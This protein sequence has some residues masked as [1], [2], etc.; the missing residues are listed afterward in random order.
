MKGKILFCSRIVAAIVIVMLLLQTF[1]FNFG[2]KIDA[3]SEEQSSAFTFTILDKKNS[4][5]IKDA[6]ISVNVTVVNSVYNT[7]E[8]YFTLD[9]ITDD[10]G[11]CSFIEI[12]ERADDDIELK[13]EY[14]VTKIGYYDQNGEIEISNSNIGF[15]GNVD[16]E[17]KPIPTVTIRGRVRDNENNGIPR[18]KVSLTGYTD[19]SVETKENGK[20]EIPNVYKTGMYL[21]KVEHADYFTYVKEFNIE[22]IDLRDFEQIELESKW[23][24]DELKFKIPFPEPIT[25]GDSFENPASGGSGTGKITYSVNYPNIATVDENGKLDILEAG[26]ITV[27]ATKE[28]DENYKSISATYNLIINKADQTD[29]AFT[30]DEI[31][32]KFGEYK[33]NEL[34]IHNQSTGKVF[35][36]IAED[37]RKILKSIDEDTGEYEFDEYFL[38][39]YENEKYDKVDGKYLGKVVIKATKNGDARYNQATDTYILK[40]LPQDEVESSE[41]YSIY[42]EKGKNGWYVSDVIVEAKDGYI[43]KTVSTEPSG[44][45]QIGGWSDSIIFTEESESYGILW[46]NIE[47]RYIGLEYLI[48]LKIDK[49]P[50]KL[51]EIKYSA[52][53]IDTILNGISFGFYNA[54]MTVS[55]KVTDKTSHIRSLS[56]SF[57]EELKKEDKVIEKRVVKEETITYEE[58]KSEVSYDLKIEPQ[59]RG[60]LSITA[61]DDAGNVLNYNSSDDNSNEKLNVIVV[62]NLAPEVTVK[63]DNNNV[64]NGKYY[65]SDRTAIVR[66]NEANFFED[67][68]KI[69]VGKKGKNEV[70]YNENEVKP[71]FKAET[72]DG[73]TYH[74]AEIKFTEDADYTFDIKYTDKSGN[75]FDS[76]EKDVFTIDKTKPK[77]TVSYDSNKDNKYYKRNR[78]ATIRIDEYNFDPKGLDA[79]ITIK[80]ADGEIIDSKEY[81]DF[82]TDISNWNIG[83]NGVNTTEIT[84]KKDGYYSLYIN[85]TDLAGNVAEEN[86]EDNFVID[87]T[88]PTNLSISYSEPVLDVILEAISF[89][90]YN[91]SM[92]VEISADDLTSGVDYFNYSYN[93]D[94]GVS[95]IN[96]GGSGTITTDAI[97]YENGI[98]TAKATFTIDP[99]FRGKISFEAVDKAGNMS[100]F[101]SDKVIV[102]DNIAP[103]IEVFFDNNNVVNDSFY[104]AYRSATIKIEE[105]NFFEDDVVITVGKRGYG[106]SDYTETRVR[107]QFVKSEDN[108]VYTAQ[109]EFNEDGDYTFD[110]SYTDKSG[111]VFDSYEINEFS[112][113]TTKPVIK[114]DFDNNTAL[115]GNFYNEQRIATITVE[116]HYFKPENLVVTYSAV[117]IENNKVATEDFVAYLKNPENWTTNGDIHTAKIAFSED[118]RY[119]FNLSYTDF[120]G[121]KSDEHEDYEFIIDKTK[122]ENLAISYSTPLLDTIIDNLKFGFYNS[123]VEVTITAD[124]RS[125]GIDYVIYSYEVEAGSS[126]KNKGLT[127]QKVT[128]DNISYSNNGRTATVRFSIPPQYRGRVNFQVVDKAGNISIFE[129]EK[130]V[131]VD[132]I[133]PGVTVRYDNN[134]P[135]NTKY[136]NTNRTA[137]IT[138]DEANFFSEDV[139]IIVGK[140]LD[141][142]TNYRET[143]VNPKFTKNGDIYTAD[144]VFDE[145]A[146][147]TFDISYTDK[148]GNVFDSY[149]KDEFTIDKKSPQIQITYDNNSATNYNKF[150]ER[151]VATIKITEHNF[152]ASD[153]DVRII[154]RDKNGN[155]VVNLGDRLKSESAWTHNGDVHTA[156]VVFDEDANYEFDISYEDMAGNKNSPIDYSSSVAPAEFTIDKTL[157]TGLIEIGEWHASKDGTVWDIFLEVITM[158][159]WTNKELMVNISAE[160]ALSGVD[161]IKYFKTATPVSLKEIMEKSEGWTVF[162]GDKTSF[163]V[164]PDEQFIVYASIVDKAGNVTYISSDGVIVDNTKPAVRELSPK[165][166][167]EV[168]EGS[169]NNIYNKDVNV[170]I[171]VEDPIVNG[172]VYSGLK[173]IEYKVVNMGS[174]TQEGVLYTFDKVK[175]SKADLLQQW[176]GNIVVD[177]KKNNSNDVKVIVTA[178]DNAGNTV[179]ETLPLMIDITPPKIKVSYDNNSDDNIFKG[180]FKEERTAT[181]VI[182]E[183]NFRKEDVKLKISNTHGVQ[184]RI[185]DWSY[186]S[187]KGNGDDDTYTAKITFAEDGDYTFDI[188]YVDL[189]NN[190]NTSVDY[191]D[192]VAPTEFTIDRTL[193]IV[194]VRYSNDRPMN[195]NYF[196]TYRTATIYITEHNFDA[197]RVKISMTSTDDGKPNAIPVVSHW[198]SNGDIHSATVNFSK[199]SLYTFDIEVTDKAGNMA[200]DYKE[201]SFYIDTTE[202]T[203]LITGVADKSANNGD[204]MPVVECYDTNIDFQNV[205]ISLVGANRN[206]VKLDGITERT[207]NGM[208][209]RFNNF[210]KVKEVDDLYTLSVNAVD[211]AGNASNKSITF[212]VNRFGSVYSVSESTKKILN[213]FISKEEDITFIETNVDALQEVRITLFKDNITKV[214]VRGKDY[215]VE[216]ISGENMWHQYIYKIKKENFVEDGVYRIIVYSVDEANNKS[217]N[218]MDSKLTEISF[219]VDKTPPNI[220]VADLES[221]KTYPLANKPV[222]MS[223]NDNLSL[224]SVDVLLNGE[225]LKSWTKEEIKNGGL[226]DSGFNFEISGDSTKAHTISIVATDSAGNKQTVDIKN[227]YVTTNLII[228]FRNNKF[229]FYGT[230]GGMTTLA[231]FAVYVIL[232]RRKLKIAN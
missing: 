107:P 218:N 40:V 84:F 169:K 175:P 210:E 25:Y 127:E 14:S 52:S 151:R 59:F 176:K 110:I 106:D 165:I 39:K 139:K 117:D 41:I 67:D 13:C 166:S 34:T 74:T 123:P 3:A 133:A 53:V 62:D 203:I 217:G 97:K 71:S 126:P 49:T 184:P 70:H 73:I 204:V 130:I 6:E 101:A 60:K 196:N 186:V 160:D 168:K 134:S 103:N 63:Y 164:Q 46:R 30:S 136:Y 216:E 119:T 56:Y 149:T 92:T 131:V 132:N 183:R 55:I 140:R 42:G 86:F 116:E 115:N 93:V 51:E 10:E 100:K 129:D 31:E 15:E 7:E 88:G 153:I 201:D 21:I 221:N 156:T 83:N 173:S 78:T 178:V 102:V 120:A 48:G 187:G 20:F 111:N 108:D 167:L 227:F 193:P 188:S 208:I 29:F 191:G 27:T 50:P 194:E 152:R 54:E 23:E 145:D 141:Y 37:E 79:K 81:I 11:I 170:D 197:S 72:I 105:A 190:G 179:T 189:A 146:D 75:T 220:I 16:V 66:I 4:S 207:H 33:Q 12:T 113:D 91:K 148:S 26:E 17:L 85:Y 162:Q 161:Y 18:A 222:S 76:Y 68:V 87:K 57:Y 195:E 198:T 182:T 180:F 174:V 47:T 77:I 185:S 109:I 43:I 65:N 2:L 118:A 64:R 95:P 142:D 202:P 144:V 138:I 163:R 1:N 124:D 224:E 32:V 22:E 9:G 89:G 36:E 94:N 228:R 177:S 45:P 104:N 8:D 157:P 19:H 206:S 223:V 212:S 135:K 209:F 114:I 232:R 229:A 230:T 99:Q 112:I 137:T 96:E 200:A 90:F 205:T 211:K 214:L 199:D 28:G 128:S 143:A 231:M 225:E 213:K 80:N 44:I 150:K 5:P 181:V 121:N 125:A 82:L 35:Y 215:T 171:R 122:P 192:S 154:G 38:E 155:T 159:L 219:A 98:K 24:Q 69:T 61:I 158:G 226:Q 147:Y 172:S 58:A